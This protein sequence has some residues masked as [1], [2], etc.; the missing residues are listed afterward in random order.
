[1][2]RNL[3]PGEGAFHRLIKSFLQ[4][5]QQGQ[6]MGAYRKLWETELAD[7]RAHVV[8]TELD[9]HKRA[10]ADTLRVFASNE[11]T[12]LEALNYL[13]QLAEHPNPERS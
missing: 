5:R 6:T 3:A 4:P 9:Q 2:S 11:G 10:L 7:F 8:Q 1:M 12:P 13:A